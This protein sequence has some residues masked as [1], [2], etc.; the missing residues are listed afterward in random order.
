MGKFLNGLMDGVMNGME[1]EWHM[2]GVGSGYG[3]TNQVR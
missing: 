1:M 2:E 3:V